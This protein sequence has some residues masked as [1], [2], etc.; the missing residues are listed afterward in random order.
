MKIEIDTN[1]DSKEDIRN[2]VNMLNAFLNGEPSQV[3]TKDSSQETNKN[4]LDEQTSAFLG[5]FNQG[6]QKEDKDNDG[7]P[8]IITY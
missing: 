2:A 3:S 8:N 5:I 7:F 1:K 4:V 6:G